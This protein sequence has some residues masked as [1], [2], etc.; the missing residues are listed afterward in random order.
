MLVLTCALLLA[1]FSGC[2][3]QPAPVRHDLNVLMQ[4]TPR[5]NVID[6]LGRP[7]SSI[8]GQGGSRIDVFTFVQGEK[9]SGK[10]ARPVSADQAEAAEWKALLGGFGLSPDT[11]LKGKKITVQVFYDSEDNVKDTV[12]LRMD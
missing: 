5:A 4:G 3:T 8:R 10:P 11:M 1:L 2:A 12:L 7:A 9:P 6:E